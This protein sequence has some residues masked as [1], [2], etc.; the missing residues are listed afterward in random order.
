MHAQETE[1][2]EMLKARSESGKSASTSA[3]DGAG[4]DEDSIFAG[5]GMD[6]RAPEH[7]Q[8]L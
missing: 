7:D 1:Y 6:G 2:A 3:H 8:K 4:I 5:I